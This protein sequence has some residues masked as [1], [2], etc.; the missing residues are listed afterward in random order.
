[1]ARCSEAG[2][3]AKARRSLVRRVLRCLLRVKARRSCFVSACFWDGLV[4]VDEEVAAWSSCGD[5]EDGEASDS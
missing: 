5:M 3:C 1:M 4:G 2:R